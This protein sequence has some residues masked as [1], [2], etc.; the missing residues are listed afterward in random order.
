MVGANSH[1]ELIQLWSGNV[2]IEGQGRE[3]SALHRAFRCLESE[4]T[5]QNQNLSHVLY[6]IENLME[7][8]DIIF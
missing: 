5:G 6:L 7:L 4:F 3:G 2:R 8:Y 1:I